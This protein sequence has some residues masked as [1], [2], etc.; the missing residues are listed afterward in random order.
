ML[1]RSYTGI[2]GEPGWGG[3]RCVRLSAVEGDVQAERALFE[4]SGLEVT[5]AYDFPDA[6]RWWVENLARYNPPGGEEEPIRRGDGRWLSLRIVVGCKAGNVK[7]C[8]PW[9]GCRGERV[10]SPRVQSG[11]CLNIG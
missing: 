1:W 10:A 4:R 7:P 11:S 8:R 5:E 2:R 9:Y 3:A 6:Y